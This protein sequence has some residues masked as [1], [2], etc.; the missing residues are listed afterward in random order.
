MAAAPTCAA[1]YCTLS[2]FISLRVMKLLYGS[3]E[4]RR[5]R[6]VLARGFQHASRVT[7]GHTTRA[8]PPDQLDACLCTYTIS[9]IYLM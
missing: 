4:V 7:D 1:I 5:C 9:L 2:L 8:S 3:V 6:V